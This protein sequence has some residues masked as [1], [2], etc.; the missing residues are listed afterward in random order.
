MDEATD[1]ALQRLVE[2]RDH[3]TNFDVGY[4]AGNGAFA[5]DV[6]LAL[7]EIERL[8]GVERQWEDALSYAEDR[9]FD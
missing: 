3:G 7:K 6:I 4:T 5:D 9:R 8:Q 1:A 2:W